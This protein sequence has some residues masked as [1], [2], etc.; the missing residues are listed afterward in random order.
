MGPGS[1][2]NINI[3]ITTIMGRNNINIAS[4]KTKSK[5]LFMCKIS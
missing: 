3:L 2:I 1:D 5:V 4:A